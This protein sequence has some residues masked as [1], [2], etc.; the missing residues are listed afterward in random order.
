MTPAPPQQLK[1]LAVANLIGGLVNASFGGVIAYLAWSVVGGTCTTV[2]TLGLCPIGFLMGFVGL[3]V[4]PLGMAEAALGLV[5]LASPEATRPVWRYVP[6]VQF[7]AILL[8]D[9]VS[10]ILGALSVGLLRDPEVAA[11]LEG[12]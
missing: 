4:T 5:T 8:G 2:C 12:I 7:G 9:F 10:P 6:Y 1:N 3:L 11:Y